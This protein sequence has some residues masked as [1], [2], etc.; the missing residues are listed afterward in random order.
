MGAGWDHMVVRSFQLSDYGKI[1]VLLEEVLEGSCLEHTM[2]AFARQLNWDSSLVLIAV[3][4][5]E[6]LGVMIGTIQRNSGYYYRVVVHPDYRRRGIGRKL[7][8]S[9]KKRFQQRNIQ[10]VMIPVD[11]YNEQLLPVFE[12][13]GFCKD[14]FNRSFAKLSIVAGR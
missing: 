4:G 3:D 13:L 7:V 1:T 9:M 5:E 11:E 12:K 6:L 14:D 8:D 10:R 2:D